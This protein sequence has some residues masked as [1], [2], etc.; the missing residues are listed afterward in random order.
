MPYAQ[1]TRAQL[2]GLLQSRLGALGTVFYRTDELNR[3]L[4]EALRVWNLCSGYWRTRAVLTTTAAGVWYVLP[5][6]ITTQLSVSFGSVPMAASSIPDM[7]SGRP[8]WESEATTTGGDVPSSPTIYGIGGVNVIAIWPADAAGGNSLVVD[9]VAAT[10]ILSADNTLVDIGQ[11]EL[12]HVLDYAEHIAMFKEGGASFSQTMPLLEGFLRGAGERNA[13][14]MA[15]D[16]YK[17]WAGVDT[18]QDSKKRKL[19]AQR[20]GVR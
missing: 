1:V 13:F 20:V 3:Y 7:D 9:G 17:Q 8:S 18:G 16:K 2:R 4:Q 6:A 10:P 15:S 11:E 14:F 19:D 12:T 5:G